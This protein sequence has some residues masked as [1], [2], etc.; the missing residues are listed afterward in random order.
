MGALLSLRPA[1][2]DAADPPVAAERLAVLHGLAADDDARL[3]ALIDELEAAIEAGRDGSAL[4]IDGDVAPGPDL[5]DAAEAAAGTV[6]LARASER[7]DARLDATLPA[8]APGEQALPPGPAS[9]DLLGIDDQLRAAAE[10]SGPF[11]ERRRAAGETLEALN[12]ALAALEADDARGALEA[13]DRADRARATVADWPSP[14]AVLPFWLDTTRAM[15]SAARDIADATLAGDAT[16]AEAAG[17]AYRRAAADAHRADMA[18]ALAISESGASL[19]AVP[20]R[21]LADALRLASDRRV[22]VASVLQ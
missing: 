10:A 3:A 2:A 12:A 13:L 16:A 20:L 19:C 14:P 15:L 6:S 8:V 17:Q 18:L 5:Q 7:V 4:I 1:A 21:R 22:A 11:V 9:T